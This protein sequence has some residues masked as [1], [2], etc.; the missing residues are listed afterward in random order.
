MSRKTLR[1]RRTT[2]P[3]AT[4]PAPQPSGS[5]ASAAESEGI[6]PDR[7]IRVA[8]RGRKSTD[9]QFAGVTIPFWMAG[10]ALSFPPEL[11]KAADAEG[12]EFLG[13]AA[14]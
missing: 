11:R 5:A 1:S 7:W 6:L 13:Y 10:T 14:P 3:A 9:V 12:F 2:H 8:N 4:P